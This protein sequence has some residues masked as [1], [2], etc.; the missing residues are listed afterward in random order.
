[1]SGNRLFAPGDQLSIREPL[2]DNR[3]NRNVINPPRFS[4]LGGL[5]GP[6]KT[7]LYRN[8][9][10]VYRNDLAVQAPGSTIRPVPMG[11]GKNPMS[12]G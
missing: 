8:N 12:T 5:D 7:S 4:Q 3:H 11:P 9:A 6:N 10:G 2:D 1:M